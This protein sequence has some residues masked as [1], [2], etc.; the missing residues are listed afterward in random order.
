MVF[1]RPALFPYVEDSHQASRKDPLS[2]G[3][4]LLRRKECEMNLYELSINGGEKMA[5]FQDG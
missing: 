5:T 4:L 2:T 1:G 3:P